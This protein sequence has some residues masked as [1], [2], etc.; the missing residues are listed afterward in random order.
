MT[1]SRPVLLE[2]DSVEETLIYVF[3]M[4]LKRDK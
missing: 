3:V 1:N 4:L 2:E